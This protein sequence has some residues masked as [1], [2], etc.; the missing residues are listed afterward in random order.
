MS[1]F[2][3]GVR[4]WLKLF[5]TVLTEVIVISEGTLVPNSDDWGHFTAITN[6]GPMNNSLLVSFSL[7]SEV[8]MVFGLLFAVLF[9]LVFYFP[10]ELGEEFV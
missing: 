1:N 7:R 5:F 3:H 8:G 4:N 10:L 6:Y 2:Q 9:N